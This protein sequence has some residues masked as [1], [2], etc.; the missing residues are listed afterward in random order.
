[1]RKVLFLFIAILLSGCVPATE[2]DVEFELSSVYLT[3]DVLEFEFYME[4]PDLAL[5]QPRSD[6]NLAVNNLPEVL[7][8]VSIENEALI[9]K[10]HFYPALCYVSLGEDGI[11]KGG[12]SY[13]LKVEFADGSI[14]SDSIS[15]PYL[16]KLDKPEILEPAE[17]T[18]DKSILKFAETGA[19]MYEVA[20][21]LCY[22]YANDGINPCLDGDDY[23]ITKNEDGEFILDD[24]DGFYFAELFKRGDALEIKFD[25][26]LDYYDSVLYEVKAV[27]VKELPGGVYT[28]RGS[29]EIKEIVLNVEE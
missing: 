4:R 17:E 7:R 12:N 28:Y 24:D 6:E 29:N 27:L 11:S 10:K 18:E 23:I 2:A 13:D 15:I 1:M 26:D 20:A 8:P 25:F 3:D 21:H 14:A 16:E 9:C 19:D 22:P 5:K